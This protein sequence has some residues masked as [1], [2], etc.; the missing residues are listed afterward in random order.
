MTPTRAGKPSA[1]EIQTEVAARFSR[2][3]Q[4]QRKTP[5]QI[6]E[7]VLGNKDASQTI[8]RAEAASASRVPGR[9]YATSKIAAGLTHRRRHTRACLRLKS[10]ELSR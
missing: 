6:A 8:A 9:R 10:S 4:N 1:A 3:Q 5:A 2:L 7:Q